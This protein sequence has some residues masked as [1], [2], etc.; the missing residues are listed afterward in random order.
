MSSYNRLMLHRLADIF[1]FAHE[2]VGEGDDRHLVLQKC[3]D[4][5]IPLVLISDILSDYDG[6]QPPTSSGFILKR[7]S[8]P[9]EIGRKFSS[10]APFLPIEERESAYDAAR[11]RIFSMDGG[12]WEEQ[13]NHKPRPVPDAARRMIAHALGQRMPSS[14]SSEKSTVNSG[15]VSSNQRDGTHKGKALRTVPVKSPIK[16]SENRSPLETEKLERERTRAARRFFA[17][18]LGLGSARRS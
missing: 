12:K 18:S 4:S 6:Y 10:L 8:S 13:V 15:E 7:A 17:N 5:S 9:K 1:G 2:S 11:E 16:V 14:N 3:P